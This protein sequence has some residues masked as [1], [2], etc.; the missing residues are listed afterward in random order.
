VYDPVFDYRHFLV[1]GFDIWYEGLR[2]MPRADISPGGYNARYRLPI[3][4]RLLGKTPARAA[5]DGSFLD[6]GAA[7][8]QHAFLRDG[9]NAG[10]V[11]VAAKS[12]LDMVRFDPALSGT[13]TE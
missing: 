1:Q 6:L 4:W 8:T 11:E 9:F 12:R 7:F 2:F 10:T 3:A 5:Q 13:F